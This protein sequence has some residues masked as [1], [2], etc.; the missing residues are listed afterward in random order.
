MRYRHHWKILR[1]HTTLKQEGI[2]T[3]NLA[4]MNPFPAIG[5]PS[6]DGAHFIL[7]NLLDVCLAMSYNCSLVFN[8]KMGTAKSLLLNKTSPHLPYIAQNDWNLWRDEEVWKVASVEMC[9]AAIDVPHDGIDTALYGLN[10]CMEIK[11]GAIFP[12]DSA[13]IVQG[14]LLADL[15]A[16]KCILFC[17]RLTCYAD[18]GGRAKEFNEVLSLV[19]GFL[20]PCGYYENGELD[21]EKPFPWD[22]ATP[23]IV[24]V[25][26]AHA[27]MLAHFGHHWHA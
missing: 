21:I 16:R 12:L 20:H 26:R 19:K 10:E 17:E 1:A 14:A 25:L 24:K 23:T 27:P 3:G 8:T 2:Y 7:R 13:T 11:W 5:P 9:L 22:H 15:Q 4:S 18:L 6:E